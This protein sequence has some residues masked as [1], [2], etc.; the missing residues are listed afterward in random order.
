MTATLQELDEVLARG[1]KAYASHAQ[2]RHELT[3]KYEQDLVCLIEN[4]ETEIRAALE[5]KARVDA[6]D[7]SVKRYDPDL[8]YIGWGDYAAD[9]MSCPNGDFVK[10][11]DYAALEAERDALAKEAARYRYLRSAD[12]CAIFECECLEGVGK[13]E[14]FLAFTMPSGS[15]ASANLDAVIDAVIDSERGAV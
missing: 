4:N 11:E 7:V 3:E 5:L 13:D 10:Y 8:K 1:E 6:G 2:E 9:M 14:W 12:H 15:A